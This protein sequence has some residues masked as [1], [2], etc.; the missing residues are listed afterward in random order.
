MKRNLIVRRVAAI[1]VAGTLAVGAFGAASPAGFAQYG[2]SP[3]LK[4]CLKKAK[5]IQDPQK[6]KKA[7]KKCRRKFG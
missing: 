4:K 5:K 7:K 6:R 1:S 2:P 3:Q